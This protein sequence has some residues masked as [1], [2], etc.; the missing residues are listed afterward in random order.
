MAKPGRA[1]DPKR[2]EEIRRKDRDEPAELSEEEIDKTLAD[3][4]P[5]SDPPSWTLGRK[6]EAKSPAGKKR[7]SKNDPRC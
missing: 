1:R 2:E 7:P 3:S 6:P 5:A 4:F